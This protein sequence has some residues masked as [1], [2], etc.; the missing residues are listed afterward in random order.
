MIRDIYRFG[1]IQYATAYACAVHVWLILQGV[2]LRVEIGPNDVRNSQ[3]VAIPRDTG[4]KIVVGSD[5][6]VIRVKELL[7]EIQKR[8]FNKYVWYSVCNVYYKAVE[9]EMSLDPFSH[10]LDY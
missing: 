7:V 6:A 4:Q 3:F 10:M 2:P 1:A 8:L 5:A 9:V